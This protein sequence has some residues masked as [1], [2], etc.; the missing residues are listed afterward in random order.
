MIS[1]SGSIALVYQNKTIQNNKNKINKK[2]ERKNNEQKQK[3]K[4]ILNLVIHESTFPL[5]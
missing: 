4:H 2:Q 3:Q 5:R 1:K